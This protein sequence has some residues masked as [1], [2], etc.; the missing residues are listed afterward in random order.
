MSLKNLHGRV[1]WVFDEDNY[2]IDLII[3]IKNI[4]LSECTQGI[5]RSGGFHFILQ[6][7]HLRSEFNV[8]ERATSKLEMKVGIL[9]HRNPLGFDTCLHTPNLATACSGQPRPP[10]PRFEFIKQFVTKVSTS[11]NDARASHR[12][13]F[14]SEGMFTPIN[15]V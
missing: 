13:A 14:P 4:T 9:A 2:D 12:L 11:S 7:Q 3:G 15:R 8:G 5:D 10:H 6:L 1:A